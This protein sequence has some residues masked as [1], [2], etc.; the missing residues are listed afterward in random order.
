M[1]LFYIKS[2]QER[3][4]KQNLETLSQKLDNLEEQ[5][6]ELILLNRLIYSL[7]ISYFSVI[8]VLEEQ[9]KSTELSQANPE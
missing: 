6:R 9:N 7:Y 1:L 5:K 4:V 8:D 2:E 3:I